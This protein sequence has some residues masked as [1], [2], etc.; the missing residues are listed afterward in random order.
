MIRPAGMAYERGATTNLITS[1]S[2]ERVV[3][4]GERRSR[5]TTSASRRPYRAGRARAAGSAIAKVLADGKRMAP[6]NE[7][8]RALRAR[9]DE[10]A[11]RAEDW[12]TRPLALILAVGVLGGTVLMARRLRR[13]PPR[14]RRRSEPEAA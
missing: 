7:S 9:G 13:G 1:G 8:G 3:R 12:F 2:V 6:C 5:W 11:Q 10:V 4:A 14:G